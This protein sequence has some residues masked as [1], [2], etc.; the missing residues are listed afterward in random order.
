M[1]AEIHVFVATDL[2]E[3]EQHL[4]SDEEITMTKLPLDTILKKIEDGKITIAYQ[5]AALLLFNLLRKEG[6]L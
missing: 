3:G 6:K 1:Q 2:E 4:D 5:I